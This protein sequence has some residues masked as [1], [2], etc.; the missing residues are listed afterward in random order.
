MSHVLF[1]DLFFDSWGNATILMQPL[2]GA[3]HRYTAIRRCVVYNTYSADVYLEGQQDFLFEEN[4]IDSGGVR[5]GLNQTGLNPQSV[6]V[7]YNNRSN[8]MFR[9]NII[10]RVYSGIQTRVGATFTGN[11]FVRNAMA[12]TLGQ[13]QSTSALSVLA[14]ANT[15]LEGTDMIIANRVP[16]VDARGW[17]IY[18]QGASVERGGGEWGFDALDIRDNII[19][20]LA[21]TD[22]A[23]F[24][25]VAIALAAR[26]H[27]NNS[28][29]VQNNIV[30]DWYRPISLWGGNN[31]SRLT[32]GDNLF[33]ARAEAAAV[34]TNTTSS[35]SAA[36]L[37]SNV[38]YSE[39]PEAG[40]PFR[41]ST[42]TTDYA[43]WQA[44]MDDTGGMVLQN[45]TGVWDMAY[46][47]A[48]TVAQYNEY[49]GGSATFDAWVAQV[50]QQRRGNWNPGYTAQSVYEWAARGFGN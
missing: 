19:A 11:L 16:P 37:R 4:I 5:W 9:N 43:G 41:L 27:V 29:A 30:F 33:H 18:V 10:S 46:G 39:A 1:E 42:G 23:N 24:N 44:A 47:A 3:T 21:T 7:Q 36:M 40:R 45:D 48:P 6:Y 15:I 50:L 49:V 35:P 32:V 14:S 26:S 20:S 22:P 31:H 28:G 8:L 2:N 17:G 25:A 38:Y 13:E 34:A 12:L